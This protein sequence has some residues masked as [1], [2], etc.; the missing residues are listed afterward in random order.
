M[1]QYAFVGQASAISAVSAGSIAVT[2]SPT[3]GNHLMI[4]VRASLSD[5]VTMSDNLGGGASSNVYNAFANAGNVTDAYF[6]YGF[7]AP[8]CKGGSTTFTA[9]YSLTTAAS[10]IYVGEYSGVALVA[11]PLVGSGQGYVLAPGGSSN[12]IGSSAASPSQVP[13]LLWGFCGGTGAITNPPVAG[14]SFG[15]QASV[16]G[17]TAIAEDV[18]DV[19]TVSQNASFTAGALSGSADYAVLMGQFVLTPTL[20]GQACL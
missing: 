12:V 4:V 6:L 10:A 7:Y 20:M 14:T 13:C 5:T 18:L 2:Y 8:N 9:T 19:L 16:W 11:N 1:S 15:G 17:S 3:A